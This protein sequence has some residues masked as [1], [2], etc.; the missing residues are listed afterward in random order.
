MAKIKERPAGIV[1]AEF[2]SEHNLTE[3][4]EVQFQRY[5]QFLS[6][7]NKVMNLTAITDLA[8]IVR[9]HF[10][11][12]LA[13]CK[14]Y[15][16]SK[17]GLTICDIGTGA[18]FPLI[19]LKIMFPGLS[20]I[21]IEVTRKKQE[22]LEELCKV[23]EFD[24]NVEIYPLDWRT[25]LRTTE[26]PIDLFV[27]RA[28]LGEVE[29]ARMFKPACPYRTKQVIYWVSE[30]WQVDPKCAGLVRQIVDYKL[31]FK[32]RKLAFIGINTD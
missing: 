26:Y 6:E 10:A 4:Q 7:K 30:Q 5:E 17:P 1:W 8:G 11:D 32:R 18:G 31:A 20:L 12:S 27:T 29:L 23:L 15:D 19:P 9:N 22:F 3:Q 25:F 24:D 13:V 28:A 21:L 16:F 2:S 14:F